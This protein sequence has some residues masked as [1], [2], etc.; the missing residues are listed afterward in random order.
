MEKCEQMEQ[1]Q[2]WDEMN[3]RAWREHNE[4]ENIRRKTHHIISN[5]KNKYKLALFTSLEQ[6][7]TFKEM[8]E[9]GRPVVAQSLIANC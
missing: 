4:S 8:D 5:F 2:Y 3:G 1:I 7:G 9:S 6:G